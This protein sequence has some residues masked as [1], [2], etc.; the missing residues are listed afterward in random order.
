[1]P[2]PISARPPWPRAVDSRIVADDHLRFAACAAIVQPGHGI[3]GN[4]LG[5]VGVTDHQL[6]LS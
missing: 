6:G 3:A 4:F 2:L 5:N 1:M